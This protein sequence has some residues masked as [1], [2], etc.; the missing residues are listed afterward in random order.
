MKTFTPKEGS[1]GGKLA[2]L[3]ERNPNAVRSATSL[4]PLTSIGADGEGHINI[5]QN[6]STEL[7]KA[8]SLDIRLP[9]HH[10]VF[11][12]FATMRGFW[13]YLISPKH[14][15]AYRNLSGGHL[16]DHAKNDKHVRV[17]NFRVA[18]LDACWQRIQQYPVVAESLKN[19]T[20]PLD[21]Y[22]RYNNVTHGV[23]VRD[24]VAEWLV[25]GI[26][27]IRKALKD[28]VEPDFSVF[29]N[30]PDKELFS[31]VLADIN[32]AMAATQQPAKKKKPKKI[33]NSSISGAHHVDAVPMTLGKVVKEQLA[34]ED[35]PVF[36]QAD[37]LQV[38]A[39]PEV[40]DAGPDTTPECQNDCEGCDCEAQEE[41]VQ[42]NE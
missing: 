25:P 6:A 20:L 5:W 38:F 10:K 41:L 37:N 18:I 29:M 32:K 11:G 33:P 21:S 2:Q 9:F 23:P 19:S 1:F 36:T 28:G 40:A 8:L 24:K 39:T 4:P 14:D 26:E 42:D 13:H 22:Y 34:K 3:I 7:G 17:L 30:A 27:V 16:R 15:D 31:D 35:Q 12:G